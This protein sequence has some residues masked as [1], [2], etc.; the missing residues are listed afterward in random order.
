MAK[1]ANTF[2]A[3]CDFMAR[4]QFLESCKRALYVHLKPKTFKNFDE[5]A[6]EADLFAEALVAFIRAGIR[7]SGLIGVLRRIIVNRM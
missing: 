3:I 1:I 2:D 7:G 5:M 6:K 4:Y